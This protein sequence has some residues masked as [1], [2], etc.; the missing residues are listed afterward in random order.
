[1][2]IFKDSITISAGKG[3]VTLQVPSV[4]LEWPEDEKREYEY[5][6]VPD[7]WMCVLK[8]DRPVAG[9][10]SGFLYL[11]RTGYEAN[12]LK[13]KEAFERAVA[14]G[15]DRGAGHNKWLDFERYVEK[16]FNRVEKKTKRETEKYRKKLKELE[17]FVA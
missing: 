13:L 10:E 12:K 8:D 14:D 5:E 17:K 6:E 7:E 3:R 2:K 11:T 9:K 4:M 16:H 15:Y 1:M